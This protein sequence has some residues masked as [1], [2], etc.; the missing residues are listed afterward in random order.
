VTASP[1]ALHVGLVVEGRGDAY[2][3]PALFRQWL[4]RQGQWADVVG[5]PVPCHGR[6]KALAADGLE[7]YVTT[8]AGRPGCVGVVVVLDSETDPA[9]EL[10]PQLL[11]RTK[12][13]T[14]KPVAVCLAEPKYEAWLVASAE[15]MEL[16]GLVY[17]PNR[18]PETLIK[19]ALRPSKY[20]KPTWQPRLTDRLD[21]D[22][23]V[24]R[25]PSLR[26][27]LSKLDELVAPCF[28]N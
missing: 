28:T 25:A 16:Q 26:R 4:Y 3:V 1:E 9:C 21:F 8:A 5:K 18:D 12:E 20:V 17:A 22:L 19:R 10:G 24:D 7:G 27:L 14:A 2:A 6:D 15:T 11:S 23:A 13:I